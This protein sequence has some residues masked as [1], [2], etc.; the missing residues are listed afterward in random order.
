MGGAFATTT[1]FWAYCK[2]VWD[3]TP[4]GMFSALYLY[5]CA[6]TL[7]EGK[8]A[9]A[10]VVA[11]TLT[12]TAATSF[13]YSWGPFLLVSLCIT[14]FFLRKRLTFTHYSSAAATYIIGMLP[15][16]LY[17]HVRMGSFWRPATIIPPYATSTVPTGA[18]W[19]GLFGLLLSPNKGIFFYAP[20]L[21]LLFALPFLWKT[22]PLKSRQLIIAALVPV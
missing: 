8:V 6:R 22:L 5:L 15:T 13:R 12:V 21:L 18:A 16:F 3:I 2:T 1:F 10:R 19:E 4:A 11:L 7:A 14:L 17:N 9:V 20:V